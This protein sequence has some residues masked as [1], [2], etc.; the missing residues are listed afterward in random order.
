MAAQ[1]LSDPAPRDPLQLVRDLECIQLDPVALLGRNQDLVLGARLQRSPQGILDALLSQGDLIEYEANAA[2]IMPIE[3]MVW[4]KGI[5]LRMR[6]ALQP[7]LDSMESVVEHVLKRLNQE[8]PLPARAFL[9]QQ[10][11]AGYWDTDVATTKATS[12]A[13]NLLRD[14]GIIRVVARDGGHRLFDLMERGLRS[15]V[16]DA[17]RAISPEEADRGL[18]YKYVR[19]YGVMDI[20][21]P[22]FGWRRMRM[23]DRQDQVKHL[24]ETR[25]I[26]PLAIEGVDRSYY[27]NTESL[28]LL[29]QCRHRS[30][31][32]GEEA[33]IRFLPPLDNLL[34][35]RERLQDI[36]DFNYRWEI[37]IPQSKRQFGAYVMPILSGSTLIGRLSARTIRDS[38]T[39]QVI[40]TWWEPSTR[41]T[42][43]L[44]KRALQGVENFSRHLGMQQFE[45]LQP[46]V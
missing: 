45:F 24:L 37:Y 27:A 42:K 8:G 33:P 21:D 25:R 34:W 5:Q 40:G 6:Q 7:Q 43:A 4:L 46:M 31:P 35:R 19:A 30:E 10:R 29:E 32:R 11:V 3:D 1:Q 22:R 36:F 20:G 13:L 16:V 28:E 38:Q 41:R 44:G 14:A 39:L 2:S 17:W 15:S 12:H 26:T 9:T 18:L 23:K